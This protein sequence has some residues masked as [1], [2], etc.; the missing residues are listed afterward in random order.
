MFFVDGGGIGV[1]WVDI[2]CGLFVFNFMGLFI[3][4]LFFI[5]LVM[6]C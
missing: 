6:I 5:L 2:C 3:L 1:K 4:M